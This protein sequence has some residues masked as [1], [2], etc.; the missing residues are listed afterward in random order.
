MENNGFFPPPSLHLS[1]PLTQ[2]RQIHR[3]NVAIDFAIKHREKMQE[4]GGTTLATTSVPFPSHH[5]RSPLPRHPLPPPKVKGL[6]TNYNESPV[7]HEWGEQ[8]RDDVYSRP[9]RT[10]PRPRNGER[11]RRRR[12]RR[13]KSREIEE[14]GRGEEGT[15]EEEETRDGGRCE[16]GDGNPFVAPIIPEMY[17]SNQTPPCSP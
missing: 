2:R 3:I 7:R 5:L 17:L 1:V 8:P 6:R 11:P 10:I 15:P 16:T 13:N 4:I 14:R 9:S 12:R